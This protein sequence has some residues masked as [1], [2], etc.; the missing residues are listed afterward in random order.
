ML[1]F[2]PANRY[3][4]K[5]ALDHEW[6]KEMAPNAN[7]A[8]LGSKIVDNLRNF[9]YTNRLKKA[10]LQVIA[11]QLSEERIKDL[12]QKFMALDEN[13]DG[14]ISSKELKEGLKRAGL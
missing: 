11:G 6:I 9:R 12:R 10:A 1:A 7:N 13:G 3:S 14:M 4:A 2:K 8:P 5:Q